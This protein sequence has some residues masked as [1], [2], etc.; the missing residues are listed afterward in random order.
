MFVASARWLGFRLDF[1]C[2]LLLAGC[3]YLAVALSHEVRR[4]QLLQ[5]A[6]KSRLARL[7]LSDSDAVKTREQL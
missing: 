6:I 5:E 7:V 3:T 4:Q 1:L 2:F